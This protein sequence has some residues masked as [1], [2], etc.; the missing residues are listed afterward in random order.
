VSVRYNTL[1]ITHF[2]DAL[3]GFG[4]NATLAVA[5]TSGTLGVAVSGFTLS[6]DVVDLTAI[7]TNGTISNFDTIAHR[8]TIS[9]SLGMM[10]LQLD[11]SDAAA[12]TT[13]SDG[14]SGT[15]LLLCFLAGT[16][17]LTEAGERPVETLAIGDRVVTQSGAMRP[18]RWIGTGRALATRGRRNAATP[19]IVRKGALADNM[20]CRDLRVTKGHALYIDGALIPVE[21]LVNHRSILWDDRAQEV[22]VYHVELETHDVLLADGA[23]AESY[24]DD[25]NRWLFRNANSGWSLPPQVPCAPLLTAG[26]LVDAVWRRLLERA[27]PRPGVPL[28]SDPD[29]HLLADGRRV[30]ASWRR[31]PLHGYRLAAR[32]ATL[33]I[34]SRAAVPMELGVTRDPRCLGVAVRRIE[35]AQSRRL[36]LVEA[37]DARLAAGFHASEPDN[38]FRWTDGDATVPDALFDG[39]DGPLEVVLHVAATAR[40]VEPHRGPQR[41]RPARRVMTHRGQSQLLA[42]TPP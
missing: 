41:P 39:F 19:V 15:E 23:P 37:D 5:N 21:E 29:L 11:T 20:P 18:I 13:Q 4:R 22:A 28:T 12:F 26:S 17:I 3:F 16:R 25:G 9:G 42:I 40:Y 14:V 31:G 7:G 27:G 32:P 2:Q 10:A 34:V 38:G 6:S 1:G 24:R 35:A 33:R 30:D 8:I 36:T